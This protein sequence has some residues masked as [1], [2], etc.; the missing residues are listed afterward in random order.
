MFE[1]TEVAVRYG[2]LEALAPGDLLEVPGG[3]AVGGSGD[4]K[5][6]TGCGCR[7]SSGTSPRGGPFAG[8]GGL[9]LPLAFALL[10]GAR[11]RR[12]ST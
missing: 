11:R 8:P 5:S 3:S 7:L 1:L 4:G 12:S 10:A 6:D 9:G 2:P